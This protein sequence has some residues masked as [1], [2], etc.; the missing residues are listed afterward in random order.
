M[1]SHGTK[2]KL[3]Y[4][5]IHL[6]TLCSISQT[7][8]YITYLVHTLELFFFFWDTTP[9]KYY[10]KIF[11]CIYLLLMIYKNLYNYAEDLLII[12][13]IYTIIVNTC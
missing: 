2:L 13:N 7:P 9:I 11:P 6:P 3:P 4:I 1:K 8:K 5:S 10:I 12:G